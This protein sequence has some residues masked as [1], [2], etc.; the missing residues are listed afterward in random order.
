[1]NGEPRSVS[2]AEFV[3]EVVGH[4]DKTL[5]DLIRRQLKPKKESS[6]SGGG[7]RSIPEKYW[8]KEEKYLIRLCPESRLYFE[9]FFVVSAIFRPKE[10][11]KILKREH[12]EDLEDFK[13]TIRVRKD[14]KN[15]LFKIFGKLINHWDEI[16]KKILSSDF[17]LS[18]ASLLPEDEVEFSPCCALRRQRAGLPA[19]E[20]ARQHRP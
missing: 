19:E 16:Q 2:I 15:A 20:A 14:E 9:N 17:D 1:M 5:E 7:Y 18:R 10:V 13:R 3:S 4:R 11:A 12:L 8:Y 6:E